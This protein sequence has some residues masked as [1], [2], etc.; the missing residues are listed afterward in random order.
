M[1]AILPQTLS[2][3]LFYDRKADPRLHPMMFATGLIAGLSFFVMPYLS[4]VLYACCVGCVAFGLHKV[5]RWIELSI[6]WFSLVFC[7][8]QT[9]IWLLIAA[10]GLLEAVWRLV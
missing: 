7:A 8:F 1:S 6:F 10:L 2:S 3:I 4:P 5:P 9:S